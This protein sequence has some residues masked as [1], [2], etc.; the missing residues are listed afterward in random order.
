[1]WLAMVKVRAP[2]L[3]SQKQ[4]EQAFAIVAQQRQSLWPAPLSDSE[5]RSWKTSV[6]QAA[7]QHGQGHKQWQAEECTA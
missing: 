1:M 7:A 6:F 4:A 2:L 3:F 5:L